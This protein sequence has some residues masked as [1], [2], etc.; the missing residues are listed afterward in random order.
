[1]V[2]LLAVYVMISYIYTVIHSIFVNNTEP[3]IPDL[4]KFVIP[5]VA[6]HWE[7]VAYFL[8]FEASRVEIIE[9]KHLKNPEKCCREVF[10]HWLNSNEGVNP[11]TW[12]TLLKTLNDIT[13]LTAVTEQ[14]EKELKQRYFLFVSCVGFNIINM[15]VL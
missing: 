4:L 9:E 11:K 14:I 13:E 2:F 5:K 8:E 10:I 3:K 15:Q 12:E 6:A 1:M 7:I